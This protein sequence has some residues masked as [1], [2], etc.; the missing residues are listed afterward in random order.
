MIDRKKFLA[1]A[2]S[3]A[4]IFVS[5]AVAEKRGEPLEFT[6][7]HTNDLHSHDL[8]FKDNGQKIGGLPRIVS[9]IESFRKKVPHTVTIDSGDIFEGTP[10][11]TYYHGAVEVGL[12]NDA[13]Y[14]IYTIGNH[15]F[16]DGPVNLAKQLKMAKFDIIN[17][18][19]DTSAYPQ[20]QALIKPSVIKTIDGQKVAFIG[21]IC[22]D[23]ANVTYRS[24]KVK[25]INADGDWMSPI[26]DEIARVKKEGIDKIVLVTHVG[27]DRD[28]L[29]AQLADV[30]VIIGGHSHTRLDEP[31]IVE[32]ADGSHCVVV[33]TGCYG[34]A[35]GKLNLHFDGAGRVDTS[36]I[37]YK[38]FE[39]TKQLPSDK[40]IEK[41]LEKKAQ[42]FK[43]LEK[44][45]LATA[46]DKFDNVWLSHMGDSALGNLITDALADGGAKYG[47]TIA[48]E[49]RGGMRA[50]I[51]KG[52]ISA[53]DVEELL[54]FA[55]TLVVATVTGDDLRKV[56]E[57][58]VGG[59]KERSIVL[60]AQ[61]LDV[62]GLKFEWD[63]EAKPMDRIRNLSALNSSGAYE[64]VKPDGKYRLAI[65]DYA[66][67]VEGFDFTRA[68]N[69]V[70]TK[71]RLSV[72][73]HD[74]LLKQMT[75]TPK[76]EG[77]IV[78]LGKNTGK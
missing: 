50:A 22:P 64:P 24:E 26:R 44:E 16:D 46:T 32:H 28:R 75:V 47:A 51:Q 30:D 40:N 14:D 78:P 25:V 63:P 71:T 20:L 11:F 41:A 39:I 13:H 1:L 27:V 70:N 43:A 10:F 15:E 21:A 2:L 7:L 9:L 65:N 59:N 42:P 69:V 6:I 4:F 19:M 5:A 34:R 37:G 58:S 38:L 33:Q 35:L 18:N 55:N 8:P 54:P 61:F 31:I 73:L 76:E 68:T 72:F 56:L 49:N 12:L 57:V 29:L 66:F 53:E 74:Y 77:R 23:L 17:C 36:K 48:M 67:E 60:G 62:H 52:E 45:V 3:S